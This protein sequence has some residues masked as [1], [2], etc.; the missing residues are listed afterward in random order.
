[1]RKYK[2]PSEHAMKY[3]N[4][5]SSHLWDQKIEK[6]GILDPERV[7]QIV[8]R[9]MKKY[10]GNIPLSEIVSLSDQLKLYI[11]NSSSDLS[12]HF[13]FLD[14]M[15]NQLSAITEDGSTVDRQK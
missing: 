10:N 14:I 1:M 11:L 6:E 3:F 2:W 7:G 13:K 5:V 8:D 4:K 9:L 15:N 12:F